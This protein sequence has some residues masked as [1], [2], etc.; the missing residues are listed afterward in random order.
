MRYGWTKRLGLTA[1][2]IAV[3]LGVDGAD[4]PVV[5]TPVTEMDFEWVDVF[6]DSGEVP[7]AAWQFE[8]RGRYALSGVE[9]GGDAAY[10]DPPA[11][12]SRA[13]S[14][15]RV[16]VGDFSKADALPAGRIKVATL[17]VMVEKGVAPDY[18]VELMA[19]ADADGTKF[20]AVIEVERGR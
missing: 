9:S 17:H 20:R 18:A 12:D 4:D 3:V 15:D 10:P 1:L 6:I 2:V 19:A 13:L 11:Y 7:L 14:R 8:L 5:A 16:I